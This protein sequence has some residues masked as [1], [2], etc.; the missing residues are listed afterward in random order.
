MFNYSG[1][2]KND[3][4]VNNEI[5]NYLNLQD[6]KSFF[7]LSG[8]GSGKTRTL[9]EVLGM[10]K[11]KYKSELNYSGK[12]IAVITYTNSACNEIISRLK[13]DDLFLVSTIHS[14]AW[15][16]I[17]SFQ[18]DIKKYV[19]NELNEEIE[20]LKEKQLSSSNSASKA[21][22]ERELKLVNK[23]TKLSSIENIHKF[24]YSP[25]GDNNSRNSLNHAQV[26]KIFAAFLKKSLFQS[27][28]IQRFPLIL[29]DEC[30]DTNKHIIN[31]L[32]D[33]VDKQSNKVSIGL[34]G[35]AMQRI[36]SDGES[37]LKLKINH[38]I[39]PKKVMNYRCPK[40]I[41]KILN[42][43]RENVD[44]LEQIPKEKSAE[45]IV[46]VFLSSNRHNYLNDE[47]FVI[48][49]MI[50]A[51][52][53]TNWRTNYQSL[54][55]EHHMAA[56]RLGFND[57]YKLF[58]NNKK[59]KNLLQDGSITEI[60]FFRKKVFPIIEASINGDDLELAKLCKRYFRQFNDKKN[61]LTFDKIKYVY[62]TV[63]LLVK[64][65]TKQSKTTAID[66]IKI[67]WER[68]AFILPSNIE[69]IM[70]IMNNNKSQS[71]E[72]KDGDINE[73]IEVLE[74]VF[75]LEI[76]QIFNYVQYIEGEAGYS[77]HQGVK[78]LEFPRVLIS[79]NDNEAK[80]FMFSYEKLFGIKPKSDT[81]LRN[82]ADGKETTIDRTKRLFYVGCS[83]AEKSLAIVLHTD[84]IEIAKT[85]LI[86]NE[87]FKN[88]EIIVVQNI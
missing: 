14:F 3:D 17:F 38:W 68:D 32:I 35:D 54:I 70:E 72:K 11:D 59:F 9:V 19:I 81:D 28:V 43:L 30:Q 88:D 75:R 36:Y 15:N 27:I 1:I 2:Q 78:G 22:L 63:K 71:N 67:I 86:K 58:H 47:K 40:R 61:E 33:L 87:W 80:G 49:Q 18:V 7:M 39:R 44:G 84:K 34:F 45:G 8:A 82:E 69:I 42:K 20:K 25:D 62:D 85:N 10:I 41:T 6:P 37:D 77:T 66:L 5:F 50:E 24:I 48:N 56:T 12:K 29:I 26:L 53:D 57:M 21:Y 31:A 4:E 13:H 65:W 46:R 83:R 51:T 16:S 55:L 76:N 74:K 64:E 60:D 23:M 73:D 52:K 79:I